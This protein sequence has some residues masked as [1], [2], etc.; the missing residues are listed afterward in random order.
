MMTSMGQLSQ[1]GGLIRTYPRDSTA[2]PDA[3][4]YEDLAATVRYLN[5]TRR[6]ALLRSIVEAEILPRLARNQRTT[7]ATEA[8]AAAT[9]DGDAEAL[10][11]LLL[12]QE[13]P[14][15]VAFVETLR[16]AGAK[17]A[18]LYLGVITQAARSL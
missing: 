15:A 2:A 3:F 8:E 12:T 5:R 11:H 14:A 7:A 17:T 1:I 18:A 6:D 13:A 10:V 16:Q 4:H 9:T